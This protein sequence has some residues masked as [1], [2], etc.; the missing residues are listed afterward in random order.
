MSQIILRLNIL[1]A[2]IIIREPFEYFYEYLLKIQ[3]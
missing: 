2:S 1:Y 3:N